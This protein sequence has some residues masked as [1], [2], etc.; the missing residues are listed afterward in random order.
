WSGEK[1]FDLAMF[2]APESD[3]MR[4]KWL[5]LLEDAKNDAELLLC[6]EQLV[7]SGNGSWL[8][9]LAMRELTA[10]ATYHRR[11]AILL[12]AASAADDQVFDRG[13]ASTNAE[14]CGLDDVVALARRYR[15]T[16]R[17]MAHW[18]GEGMRA[19]SALG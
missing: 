6:S 13:V 19:G 12:L 4:A 14:L 9:A 15:E 2:S 5:K 3:E 1:L 11:R 10:N 18:I 17:W 8:H 16:A 7:A